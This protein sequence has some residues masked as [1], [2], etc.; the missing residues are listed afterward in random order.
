MVFWGFQTQNYYFLCRVLG[1]VPVCCV[2]VQY[3]IHCCL[4]ICLCWVSAYLSF[5]A[6]KQFWRWNNRLGALYF[7]PCT[8]DVKGQENI[9]CKNPPFHQRLRCQTRC[10]SVLLAHGAL[11]SRRHVWAFIHWHWSELL[12]VGGGINSLWYLIWAAWTIESF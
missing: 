7:Q 11:F 8:S 1:C 3:C 9:L 10:I 12:Q 4:V 2:S 5:R 6:H